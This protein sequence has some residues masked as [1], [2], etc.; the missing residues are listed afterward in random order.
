[1]NIDFTPKE[2]SWL[3]F[4]ERVLQEAADKNNT[5]KQRIQFLGIYSNNLDEF[6]RVRV[7][8][9]KRISQIGKKSQEV[10]GFNPKEVIKE[11]Q[12]IVIKQQVKFSNIYSNIID[13]LEQRNIYFLNE[14]NINDEQRIFLKTY[15][16]QYVRPQLM[17]IML[18]QVKTI[19]ALKDDMVYLAVTFLTTK[20]KNHQYAL[21]QIP[22]DV[23]PRFIKIPSKNTNQYLIFLDDVIRIGL[24]DLFHLFEIN[25]ITAHTI[26]IT[27]DA[28]LDIVD[29]VSESYINNVAAS[30]KKR[31]KGEA[32]RLIYDKDMPEGILS[33]FLKKLDIRKDDAILQGSRY[34]NFK[35]F[36]KFPDVGINDE[37][38]MFACQLHHIDIIKNKSIFSSIRKKDILLYYPFHTFNHFIDLLR[39]S[40]IDPHVKKIKI[41]L[42]RLAKYSSVINALVNAARNGKEVTVLLELQARFDEEA[43]INWGNLLDEEGVKVIYGIAGLKVHSKMCLIERVENN[44]LVYYSCISNGNFNE[45][46]AKIYTDLMIMTK[47]LKINREINNIFNFFNKTYL[48]EN[49]YHLSISPFYFRKKITSLIKNEIKNAKKNIPA[50]INIKVN[51]LADL[52]IIELLY[53]ASKAGVKIKLIVRGM[54]ALK[55]DNYPNIEA[56][57][58][59][60]KLL[61]HSRIFIFGN[62][63]N[64]KVYISSS[65]LMTRNLDRR[66]EVTCPIYNKRNKEIAIE[67]FNLHWQDNIK[68]RILDNNLFNKL[69]KPKKDEPPFRS[70]EKIYE[71]LKAINI[72]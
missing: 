57:G 54:M 45:D 65:D 8:S 40:S 53:A 3:S 48:R 4:N 66:I 68:A 70:Q 33:L 49:Y 60:D 18:N 24:K 42:Y 20:K 38:N 15:F 26:K 58:V 1:M 29:D 17:P 21:I 62:G 71:Y 10:L 2:I 63:G 61:E 22:S 6:F 14:T 11:I 59:V 31:K 13:S 30:L 32:V 46:T 37:P 55:P 39:D 50:Y 43:N 34:H 44:K 67:L 25:Y 23:L 64:E 47:D 28:E 16:N 36:L 7:A 41:T 51:N 72:K 12:S 9:L 5:L 35:D 56:Y 19:P 27:K 69:R 52:E